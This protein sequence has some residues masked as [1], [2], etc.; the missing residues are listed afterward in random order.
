MTE[1][2]A[3]VQTGFLHYLLHPSE[4]PTLTERETMLTGSRDQRRALI[5]EWAQRESLVYYTRPEA[6][7]PN[8][9]FIP[10]NVNDQHW[11]MAAYDRRAGLVFYVDPLG[12]ALDVNTAQ[13]LLQ[14]ARAI[15]PAADVDL[16]VFQVPRGQHNVQTDPFNCGPHCVA[17][18]DRFLHTAN[19]SRNTDFTDPNLDI[20]AERV[21]IRERVGEIWTLSTHN[22]ELPTTVVE[23]VSL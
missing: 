20:G 12:L 8:I 2:V 14:I 22:V 10:V 6:G 3:V 15:D 17:F 21:L 18:A 11:A 13:Q 9:V 5:R 4:I 7:T 16:E 19:R 23:D 1:N